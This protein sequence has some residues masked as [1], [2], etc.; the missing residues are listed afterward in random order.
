MI[1]SASAGTSS[2]TL[3]ALAT[4]SG[5]PDQAPAA[6]YSSASN[7][8]FEA[9]LNISAGGAPITTASGSPAWRCSARAWY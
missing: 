7:G 9:A 5:V 2:G 8:I 4:R 6:S 3:M 1:I